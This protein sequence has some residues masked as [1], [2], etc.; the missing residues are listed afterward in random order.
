[1]KTALSDEAY[2]LRRILLPAVLLLLASATMFPH[3]AARRVNA[4]APTNPVVTVSAANYGAVV[5][6]ESIAA[7]FGVGLDQINVFL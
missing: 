3:I 4:Q 7:A 2:R 6:P 5:A 1:M